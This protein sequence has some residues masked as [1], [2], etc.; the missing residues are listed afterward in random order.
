MKKILLILFLCS[1]VSGTA[2]AKVEIWE[3]EIVKSGNMRDLSI[4]SKKYFKLDTKGPAL[5][6]RKKGKWEENQLNDIHI[7]WKVRLLKS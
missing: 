1:L 3:C 7:S 5:F 2:F 6:L 4:F